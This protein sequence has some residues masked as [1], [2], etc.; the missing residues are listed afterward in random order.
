M[1]EWII[2]LLFSGLLLRHSMRI[3]FEIGR[4]GPVVASGTPQSNIDKHEQENKTH[5]P[6]KTVCCFRCM[7]WYSE[8]LSEWHDLG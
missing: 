8:R 7:P 2:N 3:M 5:P 1:D 4:A 6:E